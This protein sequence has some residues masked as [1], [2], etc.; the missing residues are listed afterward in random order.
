MRLKC[1]TYK[2]FWRLWSEWFGCNL[3]WVDSSC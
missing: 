3:R 2:V 1:D